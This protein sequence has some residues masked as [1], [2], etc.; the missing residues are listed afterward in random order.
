VVTVDKTLSVTNGGQIQSDTAN[1]NPTGGEGGNVTIS[2][3][4][5]VSLAGAASGVFSTSN[6]SGKAGRITVTTPSL[7][8]SDGA[9]MSVTTQGTGAAGNIVVTLDKTLSV[10]NG[11]QIQGNTTTSN[12]TGG[13]GGNVKIDAGE[14]V[15]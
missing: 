1:I 8:M 2:A 15:S 13:D 12:P 14:S 10:T 7:A 4:Q 3:G 11:G 6:N 9:K 5:S